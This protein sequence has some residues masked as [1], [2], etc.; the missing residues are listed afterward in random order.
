[1]TW[2]VVVGSSLVMIAWIIIY[3]YFPSSDFNSEVV[4]LFGEVTFWATIL[5]SVCV[6]LRKPTPRVI[7][8]LG[9]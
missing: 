4:V 7:H 3:S 9:C 5:I 6:A 1:M 2:V 8:Q